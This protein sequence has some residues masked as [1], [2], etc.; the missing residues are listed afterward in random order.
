[1]RCPVK[2][3]LDFFLDFPYSVGQMAKPDSL[4][5]FEQLVLTSILALRE[6]AYGVT[7]H[8]K[9][10]ELARPKISRLVRYTSRSTGWRTKAWL[11]RGSPIQRRSGAVAPN[12]AT[13]S[14]P[15][16]SVPCRNLLSP[17][18]A[19]GMSSRRSGAKSGPKNGE[20][21]GARR[22]G[23]AFSARQGS[24]ALV[25]VF[26][27]PASREEVLGDLHERYRSPGQY[28]WMHCVRSLWS[29]SAGLR[30]TVG[31][32]GAPDAGF[33]HV[34][35]IP[36]RRLVHRGNTA[37]GQWG[38]LRLAIPGATAMLGLILEDA[39]A[40]PG[41]RSAVKLVRGPVIGLGLALLSQCLLWAGAR[42]L[43]VPRWTAF[44]GCVLSL[45]LSS[46]V[47]LLFPP[48]ANQLQGASA[49]AIWLKQAGV[50]DGAA[51]RNHADSQ[52]RRGHRC[53]RRRRLVDRRSV[54]T[55][56]TA[57]D[58]F[59]VAH[60]ARV[61][62][63]E[64]RLTYVQA[65]NCN[66]RSRAAG[67][68]G[69]MVVGRRGPAPSCKRY[70]FPVPGGGESRASRGPRDLGGLRGDSGRPATTRID[71]PPESAAPNS[72]AGSAGSS[73]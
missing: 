2:D 65:Q 30:R 52:S 46:A 54:L 34:R 36:G 63:M 51:T 53:G 38:L 37:P 59:T 28:G 71:R 56:E 4:G 16:A 48:A 57:C 42:D 22:P 40:A 27:P 6:D 35:I 66:D 23:D 14:K 68:G 62:A 7:I 70:L 73:R 43:A 31:P 55:A 39:Y 13:A 64:T 21:G 10:Q 61:S 49:P 3:L 26:T 9:V 5:Q 44:Y 45:L 1:M 20:S 18:S 32:A 25:A 17:Q 15:S 24:E 72:G 47:R 8:S 69:C 67:C 33:R 58:R 11:R 60:G 50:S 29:S 12:A 41:R 19:S